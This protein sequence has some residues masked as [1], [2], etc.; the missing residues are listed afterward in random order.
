MHQACGPRVETCRTQ[1][2]AASTRPPIFV[3]VGRI[4]EC[5]SVCVFSHFRAFSGVRSLIRLHRSACVPKWRTQ[6]LLPEF[7][8]CRYLF[9][10]NGLES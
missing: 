10:V 2:Q 1:R 6:R 9:S 8:R 3:G 4:S 5:M 7:G